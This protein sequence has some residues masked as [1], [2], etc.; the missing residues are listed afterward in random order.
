M[1]LKNIQA[2]LNKMG[3]S[4]TVDGIP[5]PKTTAAIKKTQAE[6]QL[7]PD[8]IAGSKTIELLIEETGADQL[9][10]LVPIDLISSVRETFTKFRIITPLQQAQFIAQV[11]HESN[12]FTVFEENLN[13]SEEA[14]KRTWPNRFKDPADLKRYARN[15]E[16]LANFVYSNRM[17]NSGVHSG[18]GW[19]YRG[20]GAIQLTGKNNYLSYSEAIG[21]PEIMDNPDLLLE[22]PHAIMSAGWY[23]DAYSLNHFAANTRKATTTINGGLTGID[24]RQKRFEMASKVL[25]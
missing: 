3:H 2:L 21:M 18:E 24:D 10:R 22:A 12:D 13:Y 1:N 6:H 19:K 25:V 9:A 14:L 4:L 7:T 15:P 11:G 23:W 16:R 5:G 17:G 20:R 8:G